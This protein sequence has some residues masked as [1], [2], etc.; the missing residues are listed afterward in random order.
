MTPTTEISMHRPVRHTAALAF[1]GLLWSAAAQAQATEAQPGA[2]V[3]VTAPGIVAGKY[4][5][6][7]L[8]RDG[9]V[10]R[11]GSTNA[12]PVEIPVA[13][14]TSFEISKGKSRT[15]GAWRGLVWGV[16]IG[17]VTG[18]VLA[19]SLRT[20]DITC[21]PAASGEKSAF[22]AGGAVGGALWG[23]VIGAL[24]GRE[25]WERFDIAPRASLDM[26]RGE[27]QLG[28]TLVR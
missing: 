28:F 3:R 10:V 11:I 25:R 13:R 18:L 4:T 19:P 8:G 15:A 20:C 9:T 5:G 6:T 21:G 27:A 14:I 1:L 26:R 17:L 24:V 22:I 16:P 7:V 2:R 12:M 23:A